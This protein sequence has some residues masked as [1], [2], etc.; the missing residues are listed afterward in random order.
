[1]LE[2]YFTMKWKVYVSMNCRMN[3]IQLSRILKTLLK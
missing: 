3:T 1:M 2:I